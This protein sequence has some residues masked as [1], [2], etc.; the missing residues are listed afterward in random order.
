MGTSCAALTFF[1]LTT[2]VTI[3]SDVELT[4]SGKSLA[5]NCRASVFGTILMTLPAG[6]ATY[7]YTCS[8]DRNAS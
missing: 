2:C 8:T 3:S 4:L 7:P 1:K 5:G 6:T